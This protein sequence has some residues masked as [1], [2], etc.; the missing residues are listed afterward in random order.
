MRD[1]G[2]VKSTYWGLLVKEKN[3]NNSCLILDVTAVF[4]MFASRSDPYGTWTNLRIV[5]K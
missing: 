4:T 2:T 1:L 5:M 3:W